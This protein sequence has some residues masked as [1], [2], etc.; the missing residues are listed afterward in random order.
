MGVSDVKRHEGSLRCDANVS[1]RP[2]G[3]A[4][5]GT[6][7]E[8]KNMNSFRAVVR[9][10]TFEIERM[11]E[12]RRSGERIVQETRGWDEARG[13]THSMRSKEYAHDY[14]YFPDPDLVPLT[15]DAQT[16]ERWRAELPE[17]PAAKRDRYMRDLGLSAYDAALLTE[18]RGTAEFFEAVAVKSGAAKDAANWLVGDVRRALQKHDMDLAR[19][20]MTPEQ[21]AALIKL[22]RD[23][24]ISGKVAKE[25]CD[26]VVVEGRDPGELIAERGLAQ[27]SDQ[28]TIA[29]IVDAVIAANAES[30]ESYRAGKTKAFEFLVGQI[31]KESRGKANIEIARKL[32]KERLG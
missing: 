20:P 21:L 25:I 1:I 2:V 16:L 14:R 23:G 10:L 27:T 19:S 18:D 22:V 24:S 30:V 32:L 28:A 5:L 13:V 7:A 26:A 31:M 3:S 17:L 11:R 4:E 8:I 29:K 9:A 15:I 12:C 6:K